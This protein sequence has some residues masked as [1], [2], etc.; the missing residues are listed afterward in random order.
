MNKSNGTMVLEV[1]G[2]K[3]MTSLGSQCSPCTCADTGKLENTTTCSRALVYAQLQ[4]TVLSSA[5]SSIATVGH[6]YTYS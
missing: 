4:A 5:G 3:E 1:K 6:P 2:K